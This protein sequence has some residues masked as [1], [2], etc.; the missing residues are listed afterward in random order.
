MLVAHRDKWDDQYLEWIERDEWD[1]TYK[2]G[3]LTI[4][5]DFSGQ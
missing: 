5:V 3:H 2:V 4:D 1:T